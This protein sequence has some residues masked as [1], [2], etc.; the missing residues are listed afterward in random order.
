MAKWTNYREKQERR[1][2]QEQLSQHEKEQALSNAHI[3]QVNE[4]AAKAAAR[5]AAYSGQRGEVEAA[6]SLARS[7]GISTNG[8]VVGMGAISPGSN[9]GWTVPDVGIEE[10]LEADENDP[11]R[12]PAGS[13]NSGSSGNNTGSNQGTSLADFMVIQN[14]EQDFEIDL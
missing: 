6:A 13:V 8:K 3:Q 4:E 2:E 7:K 1:E 11:N 9:A 5:D 12:R 14:D 10:N